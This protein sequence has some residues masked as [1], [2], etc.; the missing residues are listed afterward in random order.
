MKKKI[1]KMSFQY[2]FATNFGKQ[3]YKSQIKS[4]NYTLGAKGGLGT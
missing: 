3:V 4:L 2:Y 1:D